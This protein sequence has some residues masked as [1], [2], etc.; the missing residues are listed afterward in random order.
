MPDDISFQHGK[1]F[2]Q[3]KTTLPTSTGK[4]EAAHMRP[5]RLPGILLTVY[6]DGQPL[7]NLPHREL[8][9]PIDTEERARRLVNRKM[10]R[11][12]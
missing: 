9:E 1:H 8:E 2:V 7:G 3:V 6:V 11:R 10:G 12:L 4:G 5:A